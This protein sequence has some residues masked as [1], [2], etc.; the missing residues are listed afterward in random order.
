MKKKRY[1]I[2]LTQSVADQFKADLEILGLPPA[3]FSKIIDD[4]LINVAQ[5][6]RHAA[7]RIENGEKLNLADMFDEA[8]TLAQEIKG[9]S[10]D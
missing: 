7:E 8:M 10:V 3:T 2:T 1:Q 4:S 6:F 5:V 9:K